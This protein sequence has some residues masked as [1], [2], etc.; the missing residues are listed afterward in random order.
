MASTPI[1]PTW[2][3]LAATS[4]GM[5]PRTINHHVSVGQVFNELTVIKLLEPQP[6]GRNGKRYPWIRV[7]CSCGSEFDTRSHAIRRGEKA[8]PKAC[9]ACAKRSVSLGTRF[10][11]L[12]VESFIHDDKKRLMAVCRCDCGQTKIVRAYLLKNNATNSCGCKPNGAW[13]GYGGLSGS[14]Y[15]R[16]KRNAELRGLSHNVSIEFL[17]GLFESQKGL[18]ALTS[19]PISFGRFC[20]DENTASLDRIDSLVG[21]EEGNVQWL[22]KDVNLMKMDLS[23]DRFRFLCALVAKQN[24]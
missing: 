14:M 1:R 12:V 20:N 7:R 15:Y 21:Y 4:L 3:R 23:I 2:I 19:L 11:Q 8:S 10:D 6:E 17:W 18:C 5:R 24:P 22:H 9:P 13:K 16:T